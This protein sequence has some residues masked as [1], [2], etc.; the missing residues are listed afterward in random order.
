MISASSITMRYGKRALF[1]NVSVKFRAGH[2]YGLIGANGSGKST[3][4]KI[5]ANQLEQ[6]SGEVAIDQGCTLGYLRQDHDAFDEFTILDTVYQGNQ[7]LWDTHMER[8]DLYSKTDLTDEEAERI[9]DIEDEFGAVGGY[10]MEADAARLLIGLGF[11]EELHNNPMSTLQGGWKL[12]VLLAQVLFGQPDILLLDEPTNHLDMSSRDWLEDFLCRYEGTLIVISHDRYF[13]N[14]VCTHTADLDYQVIRMFTGNYDNFMETNAML[15]EKR[16]RENKAQEKRAN[17]LRD[18]INRFSANASKAKRAT[19][20]QKELDK[21]D[22]EKIKPSSRVAPYIRFESRNRLGDRVIDTEAATVRFDDLTIFENLDLHIGNGDRIAIIG[23][24]GA[25]KT[26]LL[27]TLIGKLKP[28]EGAVQFGET[29]DITYFPQEPM[30][31]LDPNRTA[32]DW[33]SGFATDADAGETEVRS[34]MGRMLFKGDDALKKLGV[35]SGGEK[36][37]MILSMM[38]MQGGNVIALD[39]P[40]NHLDLESIEALNYALGLVKDTLIFVSHDREFINSLAT[41]IIEI[42][43][44]QVTDYPGNLTEFDAWKAKKKREA[45]KA[46]NA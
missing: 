38:L 5:L 46:R 28:T 40:T 16:Q 6:S 33:L 4:M 9:G 25:G 21:L 39:E 20:R 11:P 10:T 43:D 7:K 34:A 13:L 2:R 22:L 29:A 45:K 44:G 41:R 1:E 14:K 30:E 42:G 37:R 24:N 19:S 18:F 32:V 31:V 8:E 3:F 12:R 35:L 17:E 26:T 23:T 27:K 15:L 36:A